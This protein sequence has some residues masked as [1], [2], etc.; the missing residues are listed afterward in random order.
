[1]AALAEFGTAAV[2][3]DLGRLAAVHDP[4]VVASL[5]VR[6]ALLGGAGLV[7]GPIEQVAESHAD[8]VRWLAETEIPRAAVRLFDL[9]SAV[10]DSESAGR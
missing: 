2:V 1:M 3:L 7:A 5:A 6:E 8:V 4:R 10:V 9:G